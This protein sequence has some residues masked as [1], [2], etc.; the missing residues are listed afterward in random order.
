MDD[1][2]LLVVD[3]SAWR[4]WLDVNE[5]ASN[6]VWLVL[7]KSRTV[8]PTSLTY[9]Q[10]LDEA[11]CSGWIDGQR[12]RRDAATFLQRFT[13]RRGGS[14]WSRRNV[15]RVEALIGQGRVRPRGR[16]EIERARLD[17]RWDRAYPGSATAD[18]PEDVVVALAASPVAAARFAALTAGERY[19]LLLRI[20]TAEPGLRDR[21][22]AAM[23]R[24]LEALE[25]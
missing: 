6:G 4:A 24:R 20:M 5:E 8:S 25:P 10:A 17:G 3:V 16:A 18:V 19:A 15:G 1:R 2:S 11:L 23:V 21:R 13:P 7:A 22:I 12:R 14:I 9:A